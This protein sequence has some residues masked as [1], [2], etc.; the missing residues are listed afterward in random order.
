L[1]GVEEWC[2]VGWG[3]GWGWD[4]I[5]VVWGWFGA[6]RAGIRVVATVYLLAFRERKVSWSH[7]GEVCGDRGGGVSS[8]VCCTGMVFFVCECFHGWRR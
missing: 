3:W 2:G 6:W 7:A 5:G 1:R 8:G 4:R